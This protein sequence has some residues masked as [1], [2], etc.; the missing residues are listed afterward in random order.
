M[1][2]K[3][4]QEFSDKEKIKSELDQQ[5]LISH[6]NLLQLE[7]MFETS[8]SLFLIFEA[9]RE[10]SLLE[11][12]ENNPISRK[13]IKNVVK[14]TLEG[15]KYLKDKGT[16]HGN[17]NLNSIHF[18]SRQRHN[19]KREIKISGIELKTDKIPLGTP[20]FIAPEFFIE[21]TNKMIDSK[22]DLFSLGVVM[23]R[24]LY[25]TL[26]FDGDSEEEILERNEGGLFKLPLVGNQI[27]N[28]KE[29]QAH[30]L[31]LKLLE[32]KRENRISVEE[33][34]AHP[35]VLEKCDVEKKKGDADDF[36]CFEFDIGGRN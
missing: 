2:K 21:K 1:S 12:I 31:M 17:I 13:E 4:F 22:A 5:I 27:F 30:D 26:P 6:K 8:E 19:R 16:F 32:L 9:P 18:F 34:L 3:Y 15:I 35:Y 28:K 23:H 10:G 33:C 14:S 29:F 36:E 7:E 20:G 24:L 11:N 25:N